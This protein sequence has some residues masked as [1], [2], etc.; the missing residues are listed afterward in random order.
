MVIHI[1]TYDE[2][3]VLA[4]YVWVGTVLDWASWTRKQVHFAFCQVGTEKSSMS[5]PKQEP[6]PTELSLLDQMKQ[7]NQEKVCPNEPNEPNQ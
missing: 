5:A 1:S 3:S 4:L 6:K 7:M 2:F